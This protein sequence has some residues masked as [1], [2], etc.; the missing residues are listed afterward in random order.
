MVTDDYF[1][2]YSKDKIFVGTIYCHIPIEASVVFSIA[3]D[4]YQFTPLISL[5]LK[6][7]GLLHPVVAGTEYGV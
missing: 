3:Y 5:N 7:R 4:R 6:N 1:D 2:F